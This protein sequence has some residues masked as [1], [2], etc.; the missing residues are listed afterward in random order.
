MLCSCGN[1]SA[2]SPFDSLKKLQGQAIPAE[3]EIT[4]T[5]VINAASTSLD[6]EWLLMDSMLVFLDKAIVPIKK[7][8]LT[9]EYRDR[10]FRYGRGPGEFSLPALFF[11]KIRPDAYFYIDRNSNLILMDSIFRRRKEVNFLREIAKDADMKKLYRHPDPKNTAMYE[12]ETGN[13][14]ILLFDG[15]IICPVTTEHIHYNGYFKK[16]KAYDFY[17]ESY[18]LMALDTATLSCSKLFGLYPPMYHNKIIPNFKACHTATDGYLLYV[19]YEAAP[20]IYVYDKQLNLFGYFGEA[21]PGISSEY[22]STNNLDEAESNFKKHRETYGYY[23]KI[24]CANNYLFRTY[25]LP[26]GKTGVQIYQEGVLVSDSLLP[27]PCFS[28]IGYY[29]PYYYALADVN[30]EDETFTLLTFKLK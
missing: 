13:N 15:K 2:S 17:R 6:G 22:P 16:S 28:F 5:I 11:Q 29:S 3:L 1:F 25:L 23:S 27:Y 24:K 14:Q 20:G 8:S 18:T 12:L 4:D 10:F 30:L 7:F 9:G 21:V 19:S 26:G